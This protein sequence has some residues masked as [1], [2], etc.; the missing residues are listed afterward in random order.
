MGLFT[1]QL[2]KKTH[3]LIIPGVLIFLVII[4]V[5]FLLLYERKETSVTGEAYLGQDGKISD[6][7]LEET[8]LSGTL[9]EIKAKNASLSGDTIDL[10]GVEVRLG[11]KRGGLQIKANKGYFDSKKKEIEIRDGVLVDTAY[12]ELRTESLTLHSTDGRI[13][14]NASTSIRGENFIIEGKRVSMDPSSDRFVIEKDVRITIKVE[15]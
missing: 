15:E 5:S 2:S 10:Q 12:G 8:A 6:F 4:I 1:I 3:M 11:H 9:W 14:T 7:R 13:E